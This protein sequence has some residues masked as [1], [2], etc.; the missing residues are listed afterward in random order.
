MFRFFFFVEVLIDFDFNNKW[1]QF[2]KDRSAEYGDELDMQTI[3][4]LVGVQELGFG[5]RKYS[6]DDKVNIMHI[7]VCTLLEPLGYYEFTERAENGWPIF[8]FK[9]ELPPLKDAEQ[10]RLIKQA[11]ID[12]FIEQ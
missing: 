8:K 4:F 3:L 12:Y 10:E 6:K 1:A 11:L 5:Y 9:E 7:A 2:L